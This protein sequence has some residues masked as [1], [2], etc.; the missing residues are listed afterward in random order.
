L[1]KCISGEKAVDVA[2]SYKTPV[3]GRDSTAI[4]PGFLVEQLYAGKELV[5]KVH[6]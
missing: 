2:F 4:V 1:Q 6:I 5:S 3:I